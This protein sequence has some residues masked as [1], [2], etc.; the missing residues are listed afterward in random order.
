VVGG[1]D[2]TMRGFTCGAFAPLH[3]GH[4]LML[5]E[6]K[7]QCDYLIVGLQ[8][9]PTIDRPEKNKPVQT[10]A[11]RQIVLQSI[12]FV[13]EVV[14]YE[15][16]EQLEELLMALRVDVRILG[17]EYKNKEFT[18]RDLPIKVYFNKR[19][20]PWSSTQLR[21]KLKNVT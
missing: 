20:H 1:E 17:E 3:A 12:K 18:G 6:A 5:Q 7:E 15:T 2:K 21:E 8:T 19:Q 9:D 16:E 11:E 10:I 14:I 4:V 13:D